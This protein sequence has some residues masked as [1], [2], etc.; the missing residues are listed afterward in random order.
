MAGK[1]SFLQHLQSNYQAS[2]ADSHCAFPD[3]QQ[4]KGES[5]QLMWLNRYQLLRVSGPDSERFLQG[6]LSCDLRD[7]QTDTARWG[8]YNNPKGRMH[9]SF[10]ISAAPDQSNSYHM[11]MAADVAGHCREVLAR[12]IV[13]SKAEVESLA[14][15]WLV[16]GVTGSAARAT[17][18]SVLEVSLGDTLSTLSGSGWQCLVLSQEQQVFELHV[19]ADQAAALWDTLYASMTAVDSERWDK[20]LIELGIAEVS[21]KHRETFIPQMMNFDLIGGVNFKK[22]CYTGQ[23]VIA[24]LHYRGEAKQRLYRITGPNAEIGTPLFSSERNAAVGEIVAWYQQG[25][26]G[27][28]L[29][30]LRNDSVDQ[31]LGDEQGQSFKAESLQPH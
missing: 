30:V 12:Y 22:G 4:D 16:F 28:G 17:L 14:E 11:R 31:A 6:Q 10:L 9:A 25:N 3:E 24:R 19:Q 21:G 23:E 26:E 13:F 15:E 29:A 27:F 2:V 20:A 7:I 1:Q 18:E 8:T 5:A